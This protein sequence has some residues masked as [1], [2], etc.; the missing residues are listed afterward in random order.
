MKTFAP[1]QLTLHP[2]TELAPKDADG[3]PR[4]AHFSGNEYRGIPCA[5]WLELFLEYAICLTHAGKQYEAYRVCQSIRDSLVY[6]AQDHMFL[7]HLVWASEW[8]E[9]LGDCL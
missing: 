5:D 8:R 4:D 3:N 7:I 6:R 2:S 1:F 9:L